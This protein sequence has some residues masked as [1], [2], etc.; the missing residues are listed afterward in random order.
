MSLLEIGISPAYLVES[1]GPNLAG[2][3]LM[4]VIAAFVAEESELMG[5]GVDRDLLDC[6]VQV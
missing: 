2:F 3:Q 1:L 6:T 4:I 5:L